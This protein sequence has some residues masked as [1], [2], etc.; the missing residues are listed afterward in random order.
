MPGAVG[1]GRENGSRSSGGSIRPDIIIAIVLRLLAGASYVDFWA[2]KVYN[3]QLFRTCVFIMQS[4]MPLDEFAQSEDDRREIF[5][6]FSHL[7]QLPVH[8]IG[9]LV[10]LTELLS[11]SRSRLNVQIQP[12]TGVGRVVTHF[13]YKLW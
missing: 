9:L 2:R 10:P 8:F 1:E 11:R 6:A 13:M 5:K 7:A 3:L 12:S 4:A